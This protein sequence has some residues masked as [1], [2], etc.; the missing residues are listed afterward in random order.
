MKGSYRHLFVNKLARIVLVPFMK[1]KFNYTYDKITPKSKPYILI[2][3]HVCAYDPILV[4]FSFKDV[5]YY[6]ASDHLF[7]LGFISRL[8]S[9]AISPIPR[10]K[11]TTETKTVKEIFK[12]LKDGKNICIFAEGNSTF[13]G[14]TG[15]IPPSIGKLANRAGAS[16]ITYRLRGGYFSMPRWSHTTRKGML[17]GEFVHEYTPNELSLMTDDQMNEAIRQ[18]LY[19]NAYEDQKLN[20]IAYKGKKLAEHLQCALY[21]CPNCLNFSTLSTESDRI[22]CNCGLE[23]RYTEYGY[24]EAFNEGSISPPFTKIYEWMDWQKVALSTQV[25]DTIKNSNLPIFTDEGQILIQ[26]EKSKKNNQVAMGT[27]DFYCD[28]FTITKLNNEK[29]VF[30]LKNITHMSIIIQMN[31]VFST[32]D[33][34]SYEIHSNF[35]RSAVKYLDLFRHLTNKGDSV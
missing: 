16:L 11:A 7:R 29:I 2:S 15:Y 28:R 4:G 1:I 25:T 17:R 3:N 30:N 31:L 5:I 35:P 32:V 24:L 18:D 20:P 8:L 19:V 10:A 26:A 23:A 21:Y 22:F 34:L 6:V 33:G 14:V 9:F 12:R 13:S 27:L